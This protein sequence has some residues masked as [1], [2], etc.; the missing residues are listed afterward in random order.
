MSLN[1]MPHMNLENVYDISEL[2]A[3]FS[4]IYIHIYKDI[5]YC[6][7]SLLISPFLNNIA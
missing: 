5:L 7:R 2:N 6:Q 1:V 3:C 4:Y